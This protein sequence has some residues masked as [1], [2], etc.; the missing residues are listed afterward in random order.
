M[1]SAGKSRL[2]VARKV[3]DVLDPDQRRAAGGLFLLMLIG[4]VFET[5]GVGLVVPAMA[6]LVQDDVASH[7]SRLA[8]LM[9]ILGYPSKSTLVLGA[10]VA[11]AGVYFVKNL[12][13]AFL[14]WRQAVFAFDVQARV[15]QKLF[16]RYLG[17]PYI[18]HL[19]NNSAQ[20]IRNVTVE[21]S[22]F[23][24]HALVPGLLLITEVIVLVGVSA[25]LFYLEPLGA[26]V[27]AIVTGLPSLVFLRSSRR[28]VARWGAERQSHDGKRLQ[29]I[30]EGL[31]GIKDVIMLGR[32]ATFLRQFSV[33]NEVIA[34]VGGRQLCLQQLPRLWLEFAGVCG[35]A[36]LVA[37]LLS[38]D[39]T[40]PQVAAAVGLFATAAFRLMLSLNRVLTSL[41]GLRYGRVVLDLMH[42]ELKRAADPDERSLEVAQ[43]KPSFKGSFA[44]WDVSYRYPGA[45]EPALAGLSLEIRAGEMLGIVGTSG[46]GKSTLVDLLLGLLVPDS[47]RIEVDGKAIH[48]NLASWRGLIGYVPQSIYL[49]D[50]SLRRNVAFG[51]PED[52]IDDVAVARAISFA[53]LDTLVAA[54]PKG[55]E[56]FV[57]ER[58]VRLSGGQRQRIGIARALYRDPPILVLDEATSALDVG[59]ESDVMRAVT[60]LHGKKTIVIVAHRLSTVEQCNRLCRLEGGRV[61]RTGAPAEVLDQLVGAGSDILL[62]LE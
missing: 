29:L 35:V 55:L 20:L 12:F 57:G 38:Q 39:R 53:Q 61:V 32:G 15:A 34:T 8:G 23:C 31:A 14:A 36:V 21:S 25:L 30:Q 37:V 58:G 10:V 7:S 50:D 52:E 47:G 49:T 62:S 1:M 48:S 6:I 54:L 45:S 56:T 24:S 44:L 41:N 2:S 51:V 28:R 43:E 59:T 33:H 26:V 22:F 11:L 17:Q 3:F 42:A 9:E 19:Q 16:S 4:M 60:A 5:L 46:S 27:V 40:P 13:L 18:F